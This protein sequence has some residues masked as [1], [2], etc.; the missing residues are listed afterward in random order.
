MGWEDVIKGLEEAEYGE[1]VAHLRE[2]V[3]GLHA[4]KKKV[5]G[6]GDKKKDVDVIT[7]TS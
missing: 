4:G 7:S 1:F 3:G 5:G 6:G 2:Y